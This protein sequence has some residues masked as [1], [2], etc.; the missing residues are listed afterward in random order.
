M[1]SN[2]YP[3]IEAVG[4]LKRLLREYKIE[5]TAI[6]VANDEQ[7]LHLLLKL[8]QDNPYR[9]IQGSAESSY[10]GIKIRSKRD[11]A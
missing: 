10:D 2:E 5:L 7:R 1:Q 6:E 11:D 3:F 4:Q 8:A 9:A